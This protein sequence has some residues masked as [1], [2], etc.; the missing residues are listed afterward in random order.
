V[1]ERREELGLTQEETAAAGGPSTATLR[2]IENCNAKSY[3][4]KTFRQLDAALRWPPGAARRVLA[5]HDPVEPQPEP[6]PLHRQVS[7]DGLTDEEVAAI[8]NMAEAMR[9]ARK[10]S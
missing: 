2:L 4:P 9:K 1:K 6:E 7:I 8:Q 10:S 3:R 5:G